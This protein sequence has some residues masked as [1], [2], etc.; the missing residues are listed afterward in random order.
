[1]SGDDKVEYAVVCGSLNMDFV[2]RGPRIPAPGE[3]ILG[4][5]FSTSIGGKGGNQ[6]V[7]LTNLGITTYMIGC[8]GKDPYGDEI[9]QALKEKGVEVETVRRVDKTTGTAHIMIEDSGEN[10]IV[11]VP[12]AN[13]SV[14]YELVKESEKLISGACVLLAQLEISIET[15]KQF[16]LLGKKYKILNV[17][18]PAPMPPE[19]I[20]NELLALVDILTPNESEMKLLT[21]IEVCDQESFMI[22]ANILHDKGVAQVICTA[23][24]KGAYYSDGKRIYFQS[25]FKVM[26]VDTTCAGDS[27]TGAL[28]TRLLEGAP[29]TDA[30][31]FAARVASLTVMKPGAQ[32][33][34]PKRKEVEDL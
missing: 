12:S 21:G 16:M 22:A 30:L 24:A 19:G 27:F 20:S 3:T 18:N 28:I 13:M 8:I 31:A 4:Y 29:I 7:A 11:V 34:I 2:C 17:L 26:A 15:V 9:Y 23:G 14:S 32:D 6:A 25:A 33:S 5:D 1:M 10:N